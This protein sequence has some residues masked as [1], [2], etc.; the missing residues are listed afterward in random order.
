MENKIYFWIIINI[1]A[2]PKIARSERNQNKLNECQ[3]CEIY[4]NSFKHWLDKTSRGKFE[5]GDAVWE[6]TKLKSYARSEVR[7]VE[8]QENLCSEIKKNQNQCYS[9]AE[10]AEHFIEK[11]WSEKDVSSDLYTWLCIDNLK[12]CCPK[13]HFGELCDPCPVD[14]DSN[15]CGERGIC[16]GEGTRSGDG[17]CNCYTGYSGEHCKQCANNYFSVDNECRPCHKACAEC[18]SYGSDKCRVC[19]KGWEFKDGSCTDIDECATSSPCKSNQYCLNNDGAYACNHCDPSCITC[20]GAGPYNCTSCKPNYSLW[21]GRCM[22][23]KTSNAFLLNA[24]KRLF[25]YASLFTLMYLFYQ[26]AKPLAVVMVASLGI[27]I[28]KLERVSDITV[29]DAV[30]THVTDFLKAN[31]LI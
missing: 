5:G 4:A 30:Y 23:E 27:L 19:A 16:N 10:E 26:K 13:H 15:I 20:L 29:Q 14:S 11:W 3:R 22:D 2:I 25:L 9:Q 12:Y 6:E 24:D 17:S 1:F 7:L 31:E 8:I 21:S 28:F 18:L